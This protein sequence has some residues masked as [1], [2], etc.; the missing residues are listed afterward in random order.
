MTQK[1]GNFWGFLRILRKMHEEQRIHP[2]IDGD[3]K[4]T[5]KSKKRRISK[6]KS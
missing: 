6:K 4:K 5:P 1:E 2:K 3:D